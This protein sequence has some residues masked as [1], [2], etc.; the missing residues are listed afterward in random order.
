M[1]NAFVAEANL[2]QRS[3][4]KAVFSAIIQLLLSTVRI[5]MW[6]KFDKCSAI[7]EISV[8]Y[9]LRTRQG[10]RQLKHSPVFCTISVQST[11]CNKRSWQL[12]MWWCVFYSFF[13]HY[14]QKE[15]NAE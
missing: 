7:L 6:A 12:K 15:R 11:A 10:A 2:H 14:E 9:D 13:A 8:S 3:V 4:K 5:R 1:L